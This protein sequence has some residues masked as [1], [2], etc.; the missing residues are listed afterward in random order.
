M[1]VYT[2]KKCCAVIRTG[3]DC[4][5]INLEHSHLSDENKIERQQ[6]RVSAQ[7]KATNDITARPSNIIRSEM[8]TQT[9]SKSD[10]V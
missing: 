10:N 2:N 7:K 1:E 3:A 9:K 8:Q 4:T 5:S 6:I